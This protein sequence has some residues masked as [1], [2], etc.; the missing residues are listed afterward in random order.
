M[1]T[2]DEERAELEAVLA[3]RLKRAEDPSYEGELLSG[4]DRLLLVTVGIIATGVG[5]ALYYWLL[6][7]VTYAQHYPFKWVSASIPT[8]I[9]TGIV[10]ALL[11]RFWIIPMHKGGYDLKKT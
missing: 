5:F 6:N 7:P 2:K 4:G 8:I 10:Y 11:T 3:E 9:V 1:A